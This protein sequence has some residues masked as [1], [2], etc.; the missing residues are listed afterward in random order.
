[1]TTRTL[2]ITHTVKTIIT[3]AI[4]FKKLN[5]KY[6]LEQLIICIIDIQNF[7]ILDILQKKFK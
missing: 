4:F 5:L 3:R 2:F 6:T 7:L 1:M